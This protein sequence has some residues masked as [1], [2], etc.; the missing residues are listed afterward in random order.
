MPL[1]TVNIVQNIVQQ[2]IALFS[3]KAYEL[4]ARQGEDFRE[5]EKDL[6]EFTRLHAI[7]ELLRYHS[8]SLP[9]RLLEEFYATAK[10]SGGYAELPFLTFDFDFLNVPAYAPADSS[11]SNKASATWDDIRFKPTSFPSSVNQVAG[12]LPQL[13]GITNRLTLLESNTQ[14]D[15]YTNLTPTNVPVGNVPVGTTFDDVAPGDV[16]N[17]LFYA[18]LPAQITAFSASNASREFTAAATDSTTISWTVKRR[19]NPITEITI[20]DAEGTVYTQ[21]IN[22]TANATENGSWSG[23]QVV[24][25]LPNQGNTIRINVK[26]SAG[27]AVV[28]TSVGVNYFHYRFWLATDSDLIN[29]TPDAISTV[30]NGLTTSNKELATNRDMPSHAFTGT[31]QAPKNV[32][33]AYLAT[34]GNASFVVNAAANNAWTSKTFSYTN[35]SGY[36]TSFLLWQFNDQITGTANI[37]QN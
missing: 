4:Y 6:C 7:D 32:V 22:T 26:A 14:G 19:T 30:L 28:S 2:K 5:N 18:T 33:T 11:G 34:Y 15:T 9:Y 20:V 24:K 29:L 10:Q 3:D 23:T 36:T 8:D 37:D 31:P 21:T 17:L 35:A 16:F 1:L 25:I 27:E 12:L 13:S